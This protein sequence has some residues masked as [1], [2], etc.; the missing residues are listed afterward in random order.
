MTALTP[1]DLPRLRQL[2]EALR[3]QLRVARRRRADASSLREKL[4]SAAHLQDLET[5]FQTTGV[6]LN[7]IERMGCR[8]GAPAGK[9]M[10]GPL[11]PHQRSDPC[12]L[13][14]PKP[15]SCALPQGVT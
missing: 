6:L 14:C 2:R 9:G 8:G 12:P 7:R 10:D 3:D 13:P 5:K 11:V 15:V 1:A 4:A